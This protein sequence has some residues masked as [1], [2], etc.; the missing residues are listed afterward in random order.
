MSTITISILADSKKEQAIVPLNSIAYARTEDGG[1]DQPQ[2]TVIELKSGERIKS[3][4]PFNEIAEALRN[5]T[6]TT[7]GI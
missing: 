2:M 1:Y 5:H 6:P 7:W 3:Y 4:T